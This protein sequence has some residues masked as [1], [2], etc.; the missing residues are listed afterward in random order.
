MK[1]DNLFSSVFKPENSHT[2]QEILVGETFQ[3]HEVKTP[4]NSKKKN[5]Q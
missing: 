3:K 1:L 5:H 2:K 4:P